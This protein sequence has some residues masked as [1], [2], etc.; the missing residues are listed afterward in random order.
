MTT[1]TAHISIVARPAPRLLKREQGARRP[2][3]VKVACNNRGNARASPPLT[4]RRRPRVAV[5][6]RGSSS[7][8]NERQENEVTTSY[9]STP[10]G[11][12]TTSTSTSAS[13]RT[14]APTLAPSPQEEEEATQDD[15]P[16]RDFQRELG[17]LVEAF[18]PPRAPKHLEREARARDEDDIGVADEAGQQQ[19]LRRRRRGPDDDDDDFVRR[20]TS[21]I[22]SFFPPRAPRIH[23]PALE[24]DPSV[25]SSS[26]DD[27]NDAVGKLVGD[28]FPR[29]EPGERARAA[30]DAGDDA[31]ARSASKAIDAPE[32]L[33]AD[34]AEFQR[35]LA[36]LIG[37]WLPRREPHMQEP[38]EGE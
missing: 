11:N 17:S 13:T 29:R 8:D 27:F 7:A 23:V 2:P 33:G 10:S 16:A 28:F 25:S 31:E 30:A 32:D 1:A 24:N 22:D 18:F 14:K 9:S 15:A 5:L 21:L 35:A 36:D 19:Q 20:L 3:A 37:Q 12:V 6:V 4:R 26:K 34:L 38:E